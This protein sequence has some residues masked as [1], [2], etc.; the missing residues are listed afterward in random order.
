MK[1]FD[2]F[3][4]S[5]SM[6]DFSGISSLVTSLEKQFG[7]PMTEN[8]QRLVELVTLAN[9]TAFRELLRRYHEWVVEQMS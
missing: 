3:L 7:K 5:L 4:S 8:E 2:D 1:P 9:S 6:D